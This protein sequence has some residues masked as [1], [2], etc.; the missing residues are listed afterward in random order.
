MPD[1]TTEPKKV[2]KILGTAQV[3][4]FIG[5]QTLPDGTSVKVVADDGA[6]NQTLA[7]P[8]EMNKDAALV[9]G[10]KVK[11]TLTVDNTPRMVG[12]SRIRTFRAVVATF[13]DDLT[14]D[15][16]SPKV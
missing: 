11:T 12:P 16:I 14:Q 3:G 13:V 8:P 5:S 9:G 15:D 6:C 10:I 4:T 7:P 1:K 2:E